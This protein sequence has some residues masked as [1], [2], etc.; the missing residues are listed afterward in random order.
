MLALEHTKYANAKINNA[1]IMLR[2]FSRL[3]LRPPQTH[4]HT[5]AYISAR[6]C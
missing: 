1:A 3:N 2:N 5:E 4:A 6:N